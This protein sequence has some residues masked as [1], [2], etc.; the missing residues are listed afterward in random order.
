M[1]NLL[2]QLGAS[3]NRCGRCCLT[4]GGSLA[5][6]E[7]DVRRWKTGG[8]RGAEILEWVTV[9]RLDGVIVTIDLWFDP[10]LDDAW[11]DARCPWLVEGNDRT[12]SCSI[13]ELRPDVCR[14]YP[15]RRDQ[16][17]S[18]CVPGGVEVH[19]EWIK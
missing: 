14:E 15:G 18:M 12:Y 13:Y 17:E 4:F 3:C 2:E 19:F 10:V 1:T 11:D 9:F 8:Q 16:I 6:T 7:Q 5:G